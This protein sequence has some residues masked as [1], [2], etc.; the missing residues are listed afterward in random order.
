MGRSEYSKDK[1]KPD[2]V[3]SVERE[4]KKQ[5]QRAVAERESLKFKA[6]MEE[7]ISDVVGISTWLSLRV[8]DRPGTITNCI[9]YFKHPIDRQEVEW[10]IRNA[11]RH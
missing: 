5:I 3:L 6:L 1:P 7:D 2:T 8:S 10:R 4:K 9:V 11:F